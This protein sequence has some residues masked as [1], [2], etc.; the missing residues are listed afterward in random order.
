MGLHSQCWDEK[1]TLDEVFVLC[2]HLA[3]VCKGTVHG[4]GM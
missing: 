1:N 3:W 4:C 2:G